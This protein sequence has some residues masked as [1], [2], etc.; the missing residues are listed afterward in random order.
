MMLGK[1]LTQPDSHLER[2]KEA[3]VWCL[4]VWDGCQPS[5]LILEWTAK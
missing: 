4:R 5:R 2:S 3:G 1:K